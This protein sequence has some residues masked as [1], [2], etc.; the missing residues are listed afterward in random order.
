MTPA[1]EFLT[2]LAQAMSTMNLYDEGHPA[3]ERAIDLAYEK[4]IRLQEEE[5]NPEFTFLGKE[6]VFD[7]RPLRDLRSWEWS[8][9]LTSVGIERLEFLGPIGRDEL[10]GFL[11]EALR[12]LVEGRFGTADARQVATSNIRFGTVATEDGTLG[13]GSVETEELATA[14]LAFTLREEADTVRWIHDELQA[15]RGLNLL[16]AEAVVRSLSVAMHGD[17]AVLIPLLRLKEYDQY[18]TTHA[19]NVAVL[20]MAL[21]ESL[22][23]EKKEVRRFGTAGLLHD[24]GKVK[25]PEEILNKPGKLSDEER[26]IMNSH[27]VEG[28][29][30]IL[31]AEEQLDLAAV[32]AYEHHIKIDG[33]GY[34]SLAHPRKCHL[35]SDLVHVCDVY[36][37]LRTDRPYRD[38]WST[39]K[40]LGLLRDGAGKEFDPG[41]A[42][43][44]ISMME[45][46]ETRVAELEN[47]DEPLPLAMAGSAESDTE[48]E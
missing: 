34:P 40:A 25:V 36:D 29:K 42:R 41:L 46:W 24:L 33:G 28:A 39:E 21:A 2:A 43:A 16:E 18:T 38:A 15:Q 23:L 8:A 10:E 22:G 7:R 6:V 45:R 9:R 3:R 11:D 20:T 19:L 30:M 1:S 14:T 26:E 5:T 37:A 35:A 44:F 12:R 13:D 48:T 32:V 27:P 31:S 4:A 47:V 17:Q